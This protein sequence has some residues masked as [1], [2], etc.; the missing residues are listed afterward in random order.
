[1]LRE[2]QRII[3]RKRKPKPKPKIQYVD[4]EDL[5]IGYTLRKG[6]IVKKMSDEE[7]KSVSREFRRFKKWRK[8][9][10]YEDFREYLKK[11]KKRERRL[12]YWKMRITK[13]RAENKQNQRTA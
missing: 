1:M 2:G 10:D 3:L 13:R 9:Q 4:Q 8:K 5:P 12:N 7:R 11:K 6:K